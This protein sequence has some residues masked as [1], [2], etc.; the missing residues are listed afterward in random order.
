MLSKV[1]ART[2]RCFGLTKFSP[3]VAASVLPTAPH[4]NK[5]QVV[6]TETR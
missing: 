5:P 4:L 3:E 2:L 6:D 1:I